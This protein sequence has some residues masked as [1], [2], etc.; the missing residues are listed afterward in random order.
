MHI[1]IV[2]TVDDQG[3]YRHTPSLQVKNKEWNLCTKKY[4]FHALRDRKTNEWVFHNS[5]MKGLIWK[6]RRSHILSSHFLESLESLFRKLLPRSPWWKYFSTYISNWYNILDLN[7][8]TQRTYWCTTGLVQ[9]TFI[10]NFV[11]RRWVKSLTF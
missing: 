11:F 6:N 2:G 4:V 5:C 7:P 8:Y 9:F 10:L 1:W 3:L